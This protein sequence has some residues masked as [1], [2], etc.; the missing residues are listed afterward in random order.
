[1]ATLTHFLTQL[2]LQAKKQRHR[3]G[4]AL[5]GNHEDCTQV[6]DMILSQYDEP[7]CF[8][9]GGQ[10]DS[11]LRHVAYNKGQ[12][13]L[14]DEC[15]L[16][17]CDL[18]TGFDANSFSAALGTL[19]GGGLLLV[20]GKAN[21]LNEHARAWLD[22]GLHQL[23]QLEASGSSIPI[24]PALVESKAVGYQP[25]EQQQLAIEKICRVVE[26]HRKRPLVMTAD[27]GR[28]KSSALGIAAAQLMQKRDINIVVTAPQAS[29]IAPVLQHAEQ[30]LPQAVIEKGT[31]RYANSTLRYIAPD[32]LLR[33]KIE[34]D[35]LLVDEA[36]AIPLPMLQAM[37][38]R[39]HRCV[40][41]STI[42]GYEGSGR[43]FSLKFIEWLKEQRP[44][45]QTCHIEQPIRWQGGDPLESWHYQTFLLD[46]ELPVLDV[47]PFDTGMTK[48]VKLDKTDL[49]EGPQKFGQYFALLVNAHYQTSPNDLFLALQDDAI[50]VYAAY[51]NEACVGCMLVVE[52]GGLDDELVKDI[53]LGLRRPK[54]QLVSAGIANHLGITQ[55]A[56]Q[57][58]LR[59]MRIA[60]HPQLQQRGIGSMM[61]ASL[62]EQTSAS[63]LSTSFGA[64]PDLLSF[65]SNN[66]FVAVKVGSS[67]D[68]ASGSYSVIMVSEPQQQWQQ[69]AHLL[70]SASLDY[71]F[72]DS[73]NQMEPPM[74]KALLAS[75]KSAPE[76]TVS[77]PLIMQYVAG[78]ASYESVAFLIKQLLLSLDKTK[79][80]PVSDLI[81][82][83]V[84]QQKTW[85]S[86]VGE[87]DLIGRKQCE[88]RLK[89]DLAEIVQNLHCK[90]TSL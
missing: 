28:G 53:Q 5:S 12:R 52:E 42:H 72:T 81:V 43:G 23:I 44:G 80:S 31:V 47:E 2:I 84:L 59:I 18:S 15:Q 24:M 40:F 56:T 17:V 60:V 36:A 69:Q 61:L 10:A 45:M 64:M 82:A 20:I 63:F 21:Q 90:P 22:K 50:S 71:Q 13:L 9:V 30:V 35:A 78:G 16:L 70:F 77:M 48:L 49:V 83:K 26:G 27:R 46:A 32:E 68:Q 19:V 34:C 8:Q 41:S 51:C 86:C 89:Q 74:V 29:S 55:A 66:G 4:I 88:Q 76:F 75:R 7:V 79:L 87:F 33:E 3:Y 25:Y 65:W 85:A 14:G 54:G 38:A 37:V 1:M 39:Y 11:K 58:S 62:A 73:L 6:I 67:R 57:T